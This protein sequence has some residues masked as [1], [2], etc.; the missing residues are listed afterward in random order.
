MLDVLRKSFILNYSLF[1]HFTSFIMLRFE[2]V[3]L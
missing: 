3:T 2:M 1:V